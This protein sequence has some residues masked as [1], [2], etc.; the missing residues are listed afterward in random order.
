MYLQ[1]IFIGLLIIILFIFL[2]NFRV[3]EKF[4]N[5]LFPIKGLE[6]ECEKKGLK[7]AYLP[8]SCL[9]SNGNIKPFS[10]CKCVDDEGVCKICYPKIVKDSVGSSVVYNPNDYNPDQ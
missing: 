8:T 5:Y 3:N 6:K 10:N 1:I 2:N 4:S 9:N 7:P